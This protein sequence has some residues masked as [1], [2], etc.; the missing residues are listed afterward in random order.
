MKPPVYCMID[1]RV[2]PDSIN[3]ARRHMRSVERKLLSRSGCLQYHFLQDVDD[4]TVFTSYGIFASRRDLEQHFAAMK[5]SAETD[6][7]LR[8]MLDA[9]RPVRVRTLD[10]I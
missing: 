6:R 9:D 3:A 8:D 1:F 4:P 5:A 10:R 7:T 2:Q